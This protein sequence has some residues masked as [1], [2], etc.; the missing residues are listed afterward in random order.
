MPPP[1]PCP[2]ELKKSLPRMGLN[3]E[4]TRASTEKT[5]LF[6]NDPSWTKNMAVMTKEKDKCGSHPPGAMRI[7]QGEISN[8]RE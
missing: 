3:K 5:L 4:A 8:V 6:S 1:P 2:T 7:M